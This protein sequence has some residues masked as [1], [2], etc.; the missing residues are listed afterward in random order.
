MFAYGPQIIYVNAT[1]EHAP[2][3]LDDV[4]P[5]L[6]IQPTYSVTWIPTK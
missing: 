3:S 2:I 6:N 4:E 1:K 5:P